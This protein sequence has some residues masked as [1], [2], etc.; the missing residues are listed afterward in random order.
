MNPRDSVVA[1]EKEEED[2]WEKNDGINADVTYDITTAAQEQPPPKS[3]PPP[4]VTALPAE[5]YCLRPRE[6]VVGVVRRV[7]ELHGCDG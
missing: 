5:S 6:T 7:D 3:P 1:R 4:V 2:C